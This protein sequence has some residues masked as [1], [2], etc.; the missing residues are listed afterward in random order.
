M[1]PPINPAASALKAVAPVV[2][3]RERPS[4]TPT[5]T[6]QPEMRA[7]RLESPIGPEGERDEWD[8]ATDVGRITDVGE[9][10]SYVGARDRVLFVRSDGAQAGQVWALEDF[11]CTLGRHTDN[12]VCVVDGGVSR[13]HARLCRDRDLYF[14]EDLGSSNGTF[15][16]GK[17]VTRTPLQDGDLVQLGP[18]VAFR[19]SIVDR[20]EEKL[21]RDLYQSSTRDVLTGAYNRRHFDERLAAELAYAERHRTDLSVLLMDIDHFKA[22]NDTWGHAAGDRVLA[23]VARVAMGQIRAEDVFARYGGEEF[24]VLLRGIALAGAVRAAERIRASVEVLPAAADGHVISV[25][26][27]VG[28]ASLREAPRLGSAQ[29]LESADQRLYAAKRAGRNRVIFED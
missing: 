25:T 11:P 1:P 20:K 26:L 3:E 28:C 27:S 8:E 12:L 4:T 9:P 18:R 24:V 16:R 2:R 21:L 17:R 19:F 22:V 29:L 6:T 5:S 23:H 10:P 14:V 7:V 13:R 15:V